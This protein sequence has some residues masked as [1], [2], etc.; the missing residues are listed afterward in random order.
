[1]A[2]VVGR[3]DDRLL[4]GLGRHFFR[5]VLG[6]LIPGGDRRFG[7]DLG[8]VAAATGEQQTQGQHQGEAQGR[9]VLVGIPTSV[10]ATYLLAGG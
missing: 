5:Q 1:M 7:F 8:L 3:F 10:H 2:G 4:H 9:Q 6:G